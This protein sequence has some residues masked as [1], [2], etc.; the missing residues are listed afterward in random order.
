MY[1]LIITIF[2]C[3]VVF[4]YLTNRGKI[5]KQNLT[6]NWGLPKHESGFNFYLIRK[7]FDNKIENGK[8]YHII[9]EN[10]F[11]DLDL[12]EVFKLIDRTTSKIG[13]QYLYFKLRT[14]TNIDKLLIFNNLTN[15]FSRNKKLI[16]DFRTELSKLNSENTYYLESLIHQ[17]HLSKPKH[18]WLIYTFSI[19]AF[20]VTFLSFF[21]PVISILLLPIFI[22]N[23]FFH[24][25]NKG[26]IKYYLVAIN[27]LAKS[28]GVAKKL[29]NNIEIKDHFVNYSF[30][31]KLSPIQKKANFIRFESLSEN[32]FTTILWAIIEIIKIQFNL[33]SIIFY[34]FLDSISTEKKSI[35]ELFE[36]IGEIDS[37][38]SVSTFKDSYSSPICNPVFINNKRIKAIQVSHPLI[39]DC[40]A[41]DLDLYNR[42]VLLTGSNMSG[43]TTFIRT[44]AINSILAQTI[45][46]CF[47][48]EYEAPFLK[49]FSSIKISDNLLEGSSYYLAEVKTLKEFIV[50]SEKEDLCLFILDELLKGTNTIER[51]SAGK[52]ILSYL[53]KK[54]HL[55]FVSTHD[56][57]LTNLLKNENYVLYHFSEQVIENNLIFDHKIKKGASPNGNAIKILEIYEYPN[58]II[59]DAKTTEL[60][61]LNN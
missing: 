30:L 48:K 33:E 42:S 18:I 5:L 12:A 25:K 20:L 24:Y 8:F 45:F 46:T 22:V 17:E 53:N 11:E 19:L 36:F 6:K 54:E 38:I 61:I 35:D 29:A 41:N 3:F 16:L 7:Y 21:N 34:S 44:I 9:S 57:E 37:A 59:N 40:T 56:I 31:N 32:D 28:I 1:W 4:S 26:V 47:A 55:V 14:I 27:E 15:I 50:E 13:Q 2:L 60:K 58:D 39:A 51:I 23:T 10:T 49:V 43:K 52:A